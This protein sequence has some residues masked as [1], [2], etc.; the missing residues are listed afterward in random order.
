MKKQA[1]IVN[2]NRPIK[3]Q[4]NFFRVDHR[5]DWCIYHYRVDFVPEE[6]ETRAKKKLLKVHAPNLGAYI[7]DGSSLYVAHK[8][9]LLTANASS[10]CPRD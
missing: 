9:A 1:S 7:F 3:L 8:L 5:P 4:G 2:G 10:L 6:A